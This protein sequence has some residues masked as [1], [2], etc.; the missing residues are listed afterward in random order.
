MEKLDFRNVRKLIGRVEE[1]NRAISFLPEG[2]KRQEQEVR[3]AAAAVRGKQALEALKQ[4]PV[5]E[6]KKSKA[7]IRVS[8]ITDAGYTNLWELSGLKKWELCGIGGIGEKQAEA[9]RSIIEE[10]SNR[11]SQHGTIRFSVEKE[12][13]E[14]PLGRALLVAIARL[15]EG[16]RIRKE[17]EVLQD[18]IHD[19]AMQTVLKVEIR[20]SMHWLFSGKRA[21]EN[22]VTAVGE[23]LDFLQSPLCKKADR[24]LREYGELA[25]LGEAEA[26]EDF[27]KNGADY[28]A[29]I[30]KYSESAQENPLIYSS[31]PAQLAAAVDESPLDLSCFR[32]NLRSYQVF[33]AKYILFERRVLLGDEMGLGK[34]VQ[35]VAAMAD[36]YARK[37]QSLFLIVCPASVLINWCR[38]VQKFSTIEPFLLHGSSM[39]DRFEEW[40]QKGGAAVT[41]FESMAKLT[42]R[43]NNRLKMEMLIIDE[44]H[45]IKNKDAQRTQNI[46]KLDEESE[47]ILLMT[48]TPLENRVEEMCGLI[49]FLRPDLAADVRKFAYMSQIP[50][51]REMLSSVYLRRLREQVLEELPPIEEVQEWCA[52]TKED[53]EDYLKALM[54]GSFPAVRRVSFTQDTLEH[55]AKAARVLELCE[56]AGAE[57]RKIVIYSYFRET[58][59]KL[60]D[61]LGGRCTGTITG[62]T[63]PEERQAVIDRFGNAPEGSVLICQT[64]AGGT[65]LNVQCA[66]VVIFCEPQIKPSL[67]EQA[68][69]RVYRMGQVRN[70]LVYHLLCED[71]VDEAMVRMLDAKQMEF[72]VY[73]DKSSVGEAMDQLAD[74]EWVRELIDTEL[75]R[76]R[77]QTE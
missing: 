72:D 1:L 73:A 30:E 15:R 19:F 57:G 16:D 64:Q 74:R 35:A 11:M 13:A 63:G 34:T 45:Y 49:D 77:G 37:P 52:L 56:E 10:F 8:A 2:E 28:Y 40:K 26:L 51:F 29:L 43:I 65:G 38:E 54:S 60:T 23:L 17:T 12:A 61:Y 33:G 67:T 69:S 14:D 71:T 36:I 62:S 66:S 9:I 21:K 53:R 55:S 44:A 48:G 3:D 47:R 32:G 24:Y 7:G 58:I 18:E 42:D 6:L 46:R 25:S 68:I 50:E 75:E 20:N 70:V 31:I 59:D 27:R 22:T 41:N 5:E 4:V 76:Y 39:E